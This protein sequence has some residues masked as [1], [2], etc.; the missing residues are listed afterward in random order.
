MTA[1]TYYRIRVIVIFLFLFFIQARLFAQL[2]ADFSASP[3]SGCSPMVIQ[4]T[5]LSKGNP[6]QWRWDLGNGVITSLKNPSATY[7]SPG[8][9]NIKLVIKNASGADSITKQKYIIVHPNPVVDFAL[10]DS[11]GCYPLTVNFTNKTTTSSG[12]IVKYSWDFGD[13]TTSEL[14]HPT[15]TYTT[16]GDFTVTLRVTNSLGCVQTISKN[17]LVN[18]S[19]GVKAEFTNSSPGVCASPVTIQFSNSSTRHRHFKLSMEFW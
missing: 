1:L 10:S 15:H 19:T 4:F 5:D 7:F 2:A 6:T 13:G 17:K 18:T 12:N 11:T 14:I 9:Y 16:A 3:V 8:T